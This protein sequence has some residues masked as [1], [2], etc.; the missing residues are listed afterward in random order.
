MSQERGSPPTRKH[1]PNQE[2]DQKETD[3]N[4]ILSINLAFFK[5]NRLKYPSTF[6]VFGLQ[7]TPDPGNQQKDGQ[8]K[9][10]EP[11]DPEITEKQKRCLDKNTFQNSLFIQKLTLDQMIHHLITEKGS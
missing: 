3:Q 10:E 4:P 2:T 5:A 11:V 8:V 9:D 7:D 1:V 6:D